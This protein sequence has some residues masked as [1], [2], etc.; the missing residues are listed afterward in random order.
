MR[1]FRLDAV[2]A[3]HAREPEVQGKDYDTDDGRGSDGIGAAVIILAGLL[4]GH[5]VVTSLLAVAFKGRDYSRKAPR[6]NPH[7]IPGRSS[8]LMKNLTNCAAAILVM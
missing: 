5:G 7:A 4:V 6:A 8:N 3:G 1:D 2:L